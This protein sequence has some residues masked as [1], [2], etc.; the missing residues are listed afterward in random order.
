LKKLHLSN[1][2]ALGS[3]AACNISGHYLIFLGGFFLGCVCVCEGIQTVWAV[4]SEHLEEEL[5]MTAW[6]GFPRWA[7]SSRTY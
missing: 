3:T 2:H 6:K 4:Q 5:M 7:R 1:F